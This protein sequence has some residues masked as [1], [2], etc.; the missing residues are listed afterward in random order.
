MLY[1]PIGCAHAFQTLEDD[2]TIV[3][4]M[5]EFYYPQSERGVRWDDPAIGVPWPLAGGAIV[6]ERDRHLPMLAQFEAS[7]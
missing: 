6:S 7:Q 1:I 5:T 4:Y 3:Y 2:T